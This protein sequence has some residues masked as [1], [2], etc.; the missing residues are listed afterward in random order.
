MNLF[1]LLDRSEEQLTANDPAF[2][3]QTE[4]VQA[5]LKAVGALPYRRAMLNR[6]LHEQVAAVIVLAHEAGDSID[7]TTRR[8]G[9]LHEYGYS[10]KIIEYLD[11][12]VSAQ[13]L[14]SK[15]NRAE[16]EVTL[17]P[18]IQSYLAQA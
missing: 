14:H 12:A 16:G 4:V 8:A 6:A 17:S 13:I 3:E 11:K 5:I 15:H 9:T 1:H 7:I 2:K 10:T 18:V